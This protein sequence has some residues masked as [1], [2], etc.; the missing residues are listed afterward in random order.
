MWIVLD[1]MWSTYRG[2]DKSLARPD[3]KKNWKVAT[4][5]PTWRSLLPVETSLD[6]Q[7]SELQNLEFGRC[8]S[9]PSWSG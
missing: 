3:W 6:G 5:R 9:F 4:F 1:A 8:S 7:I 2:A